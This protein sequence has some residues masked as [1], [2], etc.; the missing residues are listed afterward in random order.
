MSVYSI[1]DLEHLSGIKA[2]TIRIWEQRYKLFSPQ[3]TATNIRYYNDNDLKLI[4]NIALLKNHGFKI[5]KIVAMPQEVIQDEVRKVGLANQSFDE[6]IST[7]TLAMVELD[8][9]LFTKSIDT[10]IAKFG[11]EDAMLRIVYPFM[12]KIGILWLSNSINPAQEHF[13]SHLVRQKLIAKTDEIDM[14][15]K[16]PLILLFLPEGELHELGLLF[17]NLQLRQNGIKTIFFGQTVPLEALEEVYNQ[18]N[19]EYMLT[20]MTTAPKPS[21]IQKY[22]N[23]LSSKFE[24]CSIYITGGRIIDQDIALPSNVSILNQLEDL[25]QITQDVTNSKS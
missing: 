3:R 5:S 20:A 9:N 7:L 10:C 25:I 22:V 23:T 1:K 4:L 2:H 8:E 18:L 15:T 21:E 24:D 12:R 6:K 13:I 11:F 19:P 14:N 17:A 16:G